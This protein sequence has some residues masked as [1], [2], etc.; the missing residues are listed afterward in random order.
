MVINCAEC[1]ELTLD[2]LTSVS[3]APG[4]HS[5]KL[6][7]VGCLLLTL[8]KIYFYFFTKLFYVF[9]QYIDLHV[10]IGTIIKMFV[11]TIRFIS[12]N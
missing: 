1:E 2:K 9:L 10:N 7:F 4:G 12:F 5:T 8:D 6:V 3:S 11:I